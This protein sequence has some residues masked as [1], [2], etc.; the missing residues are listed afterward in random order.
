MLIEKGLGA[1]MVPVVIYMI[2][3]LDGHC[4]IESISQG[5]LP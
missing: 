1:M 2:I 4:R 3:I 5:T